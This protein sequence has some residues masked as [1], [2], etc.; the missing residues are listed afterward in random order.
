M[1]SMLQI[2]LLA[3]ISVFA[4]CIAGS[5]SGSDWS[6]VEGQG[7]IDKLWMVIHIDENGHESIVHAK[8]AVGVF[9]P[10]IA[11]DPARLESMIPVA[12]HIAKVGNLKMRLVQLGHRTDLQDIAP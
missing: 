7:R 1:K 5:L 8:L 6:P 9:V 4:P 3:T 11:A 2:A 12:Y 10:L